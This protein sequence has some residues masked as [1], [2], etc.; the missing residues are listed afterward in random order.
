M[1]SLAAALHTFFRTS[2][3]GKTGPIMLCRPPGLPTEGSLLPGLT[4]PS[5]PVT[6]SQVHPHPAHGSALPFATCDPPSPLLP[7]LMVHSKPTSEQLPKALLPCRPEAEGT[8]YICNYHKEP[9]ITFSRA[10]HN[11]M[12]DKNRKY[13]ASAHVGL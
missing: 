2:V 13:D 1:T 5:P 6:H 11:K 7:L 8:A 10:K 3:G 9:V 12:K 4:E